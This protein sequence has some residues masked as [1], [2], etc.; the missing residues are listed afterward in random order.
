ML[1]AHIIQALGY[2]TECVLVERLWQHIL[3]PDTPEWIAS[4]HLRHQSNRVDNRRAV[5]DW[6]VK[7]Y[8][9][10][11]DRFSQRRM[12]WLPWRWSAFCSNEDRDQVEAFFSRHAK[13]HDGGKRALRNVLEYIEI[14]AAVARVQTERTETV[15]AD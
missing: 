9:Q 5:F 13:E 1:R 8:S 10:L 11:P 6:I 15:I 3:G 4:E 12:R 14:C 7:S 2:R